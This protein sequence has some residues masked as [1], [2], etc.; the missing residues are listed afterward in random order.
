[1]VLAWCSNKKETFGK[2]GLI[3][4]EHTDIVPIKL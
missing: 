3:D 1:M 2:Y 4:F